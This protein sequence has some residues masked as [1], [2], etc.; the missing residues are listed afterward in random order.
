MLKGGG[1]FG[2]LVLVV[3]GCRGADEV[4]EVGRVVEARDVSADAE[5]V[6]ER[7]TARPLPAV[8]ENGARAA[9]ICSPFVVSGDLTVIAT[10][11]YA[12]RRYDGPQRWSLIAPTRGEPCGLLV[13]RGRVYWTE[14]GWKSGGHGRVMSAL[15][16]GTDVV[17]VATGQDGATAIVAGERGLYWFECGTGILWRA[18]WRG[19]VEQ[20]ARVEPDRS[21]YTHTCP[22]RGTVSV[23]GMIVWAHSVD[24]RIRLSYAM[25]DGSG[26]REIAAFDYPHTARHELAVLDGVAYLHLFRAPQEPSEDDHAIVKVRISDGR[27]DVLWNDGP[28]LIG[29]HRGQILWAD[30]EG[31]VYT[32]HQGHP[33]RIG[34]LPRQALRSFTPHDDGIIWNDGHQ[35]HHTNW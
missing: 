5:R 33:R 25:E 16:D 19:P 20:A 31:T 15:P 28:H 6:E 7:E 32:E 26:S 8:L 10:Q 18:P 2:V 9:P 24:D 22:D 17:E 14:A 11:N 34:T 27:T 12:I 29:A 21:R 1:V 30:F 23:D 35:L 4:P 13:D 3:P